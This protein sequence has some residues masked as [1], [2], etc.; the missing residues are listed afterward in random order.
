MKRF[1]ATAFVALLATALH[2]QT[3]KDGLYF[4]QDDAFG[5]SGWRAQVVLTVK[6]GKIA[7]ANWNAVSNLAGVADKK[8]YDKAGKYGMVKFGKAQAEWY[9]Q[10]EKVEAHLVKTQDVNFSKYTNA[11]GSTD[12]I[13]GASIHVKEFFDL[14]KKAVAAGPVAKGPYGK[15]GWYY[16]EAAAFDEKTGWKDTVLV[17]VVNGRIVD[18]LWNGISKDTK[19]KSKIVDS[20]SGAYGMVKFGKAQAEWHEQTAKAEAALVAAQDPAKVKV[21]ADGKPDAIAGVSIAISD[22]LK[23]AVEALKAAK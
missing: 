17:T 10:A 23:L 22:F 20:A 7:A 19:K 8:T 9:Q 18:V 14:A 2:G 4:A 1:I 16:A 13:S 11:E 3:L 6:S 21:K 5:S 15:D 12:A